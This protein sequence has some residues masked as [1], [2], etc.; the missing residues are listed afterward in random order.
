M[1][2]REICVSTTQF[3]LL[4]TSH[5]MCMHDLAITLSNTRQGMTATRTVVHLAL[6]LVSVSATAQPS[7]KTVI[8]AMPI[9]VPGWAFPTT[10]PPYQAATTPFDSL[11]ALRVPASSRSFTLAQ[12]TNVNAPPDWSPETHP[13]M[14]ASVARGRTGSV[15]ACGYCHLPDGQGRSENSTLAG[16]PAEYIIRQVAD[17]R[18]RARRGAV[19]TWSPTSHMLD[20]ADSATSREVAEA[21]RYFARIKVKPRFQVAERTEIPLTYQVGGLYAVAPGGN[22]EAL[23]HRIIE[24]TDDLERHELRDATTTFT[25][26]VPIGSIEAGRRIA[27]AIGKKPVA[28][29]ITCH[30]ATLRGVGVIPPIAGRSPSYLFRQLLAFRNGARAGATSAP[31]QDVASTLSL[32]DMIAVAAYAGSLRPSR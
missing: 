2:R 18:S 17:L 15:W 13:R 25:A 27:T 32:N 24:I 16:L 28:A 4:S 6:A 30:G 11:T 26:F 19:D 1:D 31:M 9:E 5:V 12:V 20:V 3:T 8:S 23:G 22:K 7:K 29:C 21:A 14:P 10:S